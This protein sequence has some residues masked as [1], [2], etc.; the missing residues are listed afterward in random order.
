MKIIT[1]IVLINAAAALL[2]AVLTTMSV[3][4]NP[5]SDFLMW[6]GLCC[7]GIGVLNLIVAVIIFLTGKQNYEAGR[8][9]L[10][11][12]GILLLTGFAVCGGAANIY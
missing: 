12:S 6:L 3:R 4:G 7:L 1:K 2:I 5:Y 9:F 8:G 10:L 11:S